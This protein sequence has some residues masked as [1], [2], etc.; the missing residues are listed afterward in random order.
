MIAARCVR[1]RFPIMG[2]DP[3]L[4]RGVADKLKAASKYP[5]DPHPA[6]SAIYPAV[7]AVLAHLAMYA[8]LLEGVCV[9]CSIAERNPKPP[10]LR[11][12]PD[13]FGSA[14]IGIEDWMRSTH[15]EKR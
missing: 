7:G 6:S 15:G 9:V 10:Q 4:V 8:S 12:V 3:A 1:C 2:G 13:D 11:A 5:V 14:E